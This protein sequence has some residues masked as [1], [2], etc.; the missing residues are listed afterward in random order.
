M[1]VALLHDGGSEEW[2]AA[3]VAAVLANVREIAEILKAAGHTAEAVP[4]CLA[5]LS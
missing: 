4:V 1:R 3:D 5:D 2:S